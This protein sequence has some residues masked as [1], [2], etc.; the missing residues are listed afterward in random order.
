M[1]ET[2]DEV[3][4]IAERAA[5][6]GYPALKLGWGPLG[7]DPAQDVALARAARDAL[8]PERTLML[9]GG[10]AYTVKTALQRSSSPSWRHRFSR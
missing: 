1:P 10:R 5:S 2:V 8:G 4:R 7:R 6:D 9:D 3:R